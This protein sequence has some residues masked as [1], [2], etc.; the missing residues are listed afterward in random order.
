M[1]CG[2]IAVPVGECLGSTIGI[3]F[4]KDSFLSSVHVLLELCRTSE[5]IN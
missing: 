1:E 3:C 4:I 2:F 5:I